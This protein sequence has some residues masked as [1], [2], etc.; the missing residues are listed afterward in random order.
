[1]G[2]VKR[3]DRYAVPAFLFVRRPILNVDCRERGNRLRNRAVMR[4]CVTR[5]GAW[6]ALFMLVAGCTAGP[7]YQ[8]VKRHVPPEGATAQAC[9]TQCAAATEHCKRDC[10]ARYQACA[11]SVLPDAQ[12]RYGDL[13]RQYDAALAQY[14]WELDRYR[15]D[16]MMGWGWGDPY[17][18]P[19]G[20]TGWYPAFPPPLPPA[21]PSLDREIARFTAERCDR[22]CGCQSAYDSCFLA[23]GGRIEHESRCIA[24]CPEPG[25]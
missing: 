3:R 12:A 19:W 16:L 2:T 11:K 20:G 10:E 17:W 22:D 9:L 13:L 5:L 7:R 8:T 18:G 24:N 14:R 23:C 21:A 4:E 25:K 1:M 6:A 15:M